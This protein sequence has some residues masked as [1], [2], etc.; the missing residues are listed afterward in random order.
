M[1][2]VTIADEVIRLGQLLQLA[3]LVDGGSEAK[4][5]IAAGEVAVNGEVDLRRGRQLRH[6][7]VVEALGEVVQVVSEVVPPDAG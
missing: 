2:S 3:G 6:G 1:R 5:V 4:Y 7:D